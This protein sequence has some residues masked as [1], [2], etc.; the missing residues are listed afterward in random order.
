[1]TAPGWRAVAGDEFSVRESVGGTRGLIESSAPGV[2]FVTA[3]LIW[4]GFR[5]PT[6]SA[7]AIVVLMVATRLVQ[8]AP[9]TQAVGGVVG[10]GLGALWAWR[11]G[12]AGGYFVP[13]LWTNGATLVALVL[14]IAIGW[15]IV[16]VVVALARG[17][18][19]AW[20]GDRRLRR[21]FSV[22]TAIMAAL[23]AVKLAVQLPLYYA[24]QVTAL[25]VAK[26]AMGIPLF[27]LV[28]WAIWLMVRNEE[29][30]PAPAQPRA[31]S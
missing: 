4:G 16:G 21:K 27:V 20:R 6:L 29:L 24:H 1:V 19:M 7:C 26:L 9:V 5:I 3:Y 15:P 18:G 2:V 25:G 12:D 11:Y 10:V 23:F 28:A 13:G 30:P 14:S 22:A 17:H 31:S 8:R